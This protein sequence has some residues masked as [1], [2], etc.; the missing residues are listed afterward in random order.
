V[1]LAELV[2]K[3]SIDNPVYYFAAIR[4]MA[5]E[6]SGEATTFNVVRNLSVRRA[7]AR[8]GN[9]LRE[10]WFSCAKVAR[11]S[12]DWYCPDLR[13]GRGDQRKRHCSYHDAAF[14]SWIKAG[15]INLKQ[16]VIGGTTALVV[17]SA[18]LLVV[19]YVYMDTGDSLSPSPYFC[20]PYRTIGWED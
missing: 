15:R 19:N 7:T 8:H 1:Y 18:G 11:L 10:Q 4:Q 2:S 9:A 16:L 17:F 13:C 5:I 3:V 14:Y 6:A 12:R 20:Q